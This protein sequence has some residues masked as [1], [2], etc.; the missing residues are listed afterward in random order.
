[1]HPFTAEP[2]GNWA[3]PLI[4][5]RDAWCLGIEALDA[6]HQELVRL[7]NQLLEAQA[8]TLAEGGPRGT[9]GAGKTSRGRANRRASRRSSSIST[10]IFPARTTS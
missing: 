6:A 9:P 10:P 8:E 7:L 3:S 1:M 5:W 2:R 4:V